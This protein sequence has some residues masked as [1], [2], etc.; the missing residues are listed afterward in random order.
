MVGSTSA[1]LTGLSNDSMRFA[2]AHSH[3]T[4]KIHVGYLKKMVRKVEK[5]SIIKYNLNFNS[6]M[7]F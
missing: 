3:K 4:I 1:S 7:P 6:S 2:H 5:M